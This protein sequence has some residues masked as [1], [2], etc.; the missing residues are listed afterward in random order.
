MNVGVEFLQ[1]VRLSWKRTYAPITIRSVYGHFFPWLFAY[2]PAWITGICE[3]LFPVKD[4]QL[5]YAAWETY[6]ANEVFPE[7]YASLKLQYELAISEL[8]KF[9]KTRRYWSDP[10]ERLA[11]H[12]VIA[13]AYRV[14]DGKTA[15][16]V[17]FFRVATA[18][19]R[20]HAVSFGGRAYVLR[21]SERFDEIPP[22]T[23]RLQ[24]FWEWRLAESGDR[25]ELQE[26]GWWIRA[27]RFDDEW[28]LG[29]LVDTLNKSEGAIEADISVMNALSEL[30]PKYPKLCAEVLTRI[31]KSRF[32]ERWMLGSGG[33]AQHI[34]TDVYNSQSEETRKMALHLI[35]HLTKL[36]FE[37]YR[38][39]L[40]ETR[41]N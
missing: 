1:S 17:K 13:Y 3:R 5:R 19:Q 16:W 41:R 37:Q 35:D 21:D 10:V 32:T 18:K 2:D 31:V 11:E 7:V 24:E 27:G 26:F 25:E 8:R 40:D 22:D 33:K 28:M 23:S 20:G 34:L 29:R 4:T 14:E 38:Q 6:L 15:N 36:G 9:K 30:A 39:I 12:M